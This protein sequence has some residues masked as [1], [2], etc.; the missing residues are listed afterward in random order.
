[1]A[2]EV[3][4]TRFS[5]PPVL[6]TAELHHTTYLYEELKTEW[7]NPKPDL[8]KCGELLAELKVIRKRH[9]DIDEGL[10]FTIH[11]VITIFLLY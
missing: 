9:N 5:A 10:S 8:K 7:E 3:K 11:V 2:A 6:S 1:M 4:K